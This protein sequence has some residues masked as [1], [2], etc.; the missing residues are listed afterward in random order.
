MP[1]APTN[2]SLSQQQTSTLLYRMKAMIKASKRDRKELLSFFVGW[3]IWK[4]RNRLL[5]E[6]KRE[7]IVHVVHSSISNFQLWQEANSSTEDMDTITNK[8]P[9]SLQE[10]IPEEAEYYCLTDASWITPA[11][12][13]GIGWSLFRKEGTLVTQGSSAILPT[14]TDF[15]AEAIA[16][17]MAV[18]QLKALSYKRIAFLS[19]NKQMVNGT[20][21]LSYSGVRA[22]ENCTEAAIIIQDILNLSWGDEF[23]YH[24]VPRNFVSIYS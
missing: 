6:N 23:S 15:Q 4:M 14:E 24:F 12:T 3:R 17:C 11:T 7:H 20:N 19:D 16:L 21:Q 18:Q 5:Y 10:V 1:L 9:S 8:Q 13:A 22:P 2:C